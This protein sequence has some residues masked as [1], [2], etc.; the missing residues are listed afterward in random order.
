MAETIGY[1]FTDMRDAET[2][3]LDDLR[4]EIAKLKNLVGFY[5]TKQLALKKFINSLYGALASKYFVGYNVDV[6]ESITAQGRDLNHFSE[7]SV[8]DYFEGIFQSN[9]EITLFYQWVHYDDEG[10]RITF[11]KSADYPNYYNVGKWE[12]CKS[13]EPAVKKGKK[14][15]PEMKACLKDN[16]TGHCDWF[17]TKVGLWQKLGADPR[18]AESFDIDKGRTTK[19]PKLTGSDYSYLKNNQNVSLTVAGDTDSIYVEFGRV[20]RHCQI[21]KE[22]QVQFVVDLWDYSLGPFMEQRYEDYANMFNCP[23]NIQVLEL[24]KVSDV[25]MYFAKKRYCMSEAWVEGPGMIEAGSRTVFKGVEIIKGSTAAFAKDVLADF[26]K[27][28]LSWYREH[29]EAIEYGTVIQKL[30][31]YKQRFDVQPPED[32]C[33]GASVGDYE[34]FILSD[35]SYTTGNGSASTLVVG[36]KCPAHVRAAGIYNYMLNQPANRKYKVKY[37][38]IKTA[39]KVRWYYAKKN[40]KNDEF[41]I[42]AFLPG[43]F[44]AEFA[45]PMDK[46]VQFEKTILS[47]CNKVISDILGY[48]PVT[49]ALTWSASLF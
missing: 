3:S 32:L 49:A 27:F 47:Y 37:S 16:S 28:I 39:D 33:F 10:N 42:F 30:K 5:E 24:E 7:N 8:N 4:K 15:T 18:L 45:L 9:P 14:L 35:G 40:G 12:E 34:K 25:T 20:C 6:A 21:P 17:Q 31:T 2:V 13:W 19:I 22:R 29:D 11:K 44:P 43:S 48:P 46:D 1:K 36:D 41:D 23:K 38:P 26:S